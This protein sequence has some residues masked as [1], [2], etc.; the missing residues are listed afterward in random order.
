MVSVRTWLVKFNCIQRMLPPT[1]MC[2]KRPRIAKTSYEFALLRYDS[3]NNICLYKHMLLSNKVSFYYTVIIR[4]KIL[5]FDEAKDV[6]C[7][8]VGGAGLVAAEMIERADGV[9]F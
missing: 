2:V 4:D 8:G 6:E 1:S 9:E 5:L 7:F 3:I